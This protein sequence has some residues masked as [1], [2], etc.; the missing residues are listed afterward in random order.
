MSCRR[1]F[2]VQKPIFPEQLQADPVAVVED[3][4]ATRDQ[5]VQIFDNLVRLVQDRPAM[6]DEPNLGR[7]TVARDQGLDQR[8]RLVTAGFDQ[9]QVA[10]VQRT[11]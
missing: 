4:P 3:D 1:R 11:G 5:A 8:G 6:V 7:Q 10:G 9:D 2:K